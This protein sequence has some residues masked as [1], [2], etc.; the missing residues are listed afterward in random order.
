M[1]DLQSGK[2]FLGCIARGA[3]SNRSILAIPASPA[4]AAIA[5]S[6]TIFADN[7]IFKHL[8]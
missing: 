7:F 3:F 5:A 6:L 1:T 4:P 8:P 2:M